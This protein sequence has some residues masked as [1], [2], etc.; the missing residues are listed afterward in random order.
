MHTLVLAL[1]LSLSAPAAAMSADE[2]EQIRLMDEM[3]QLARRNVWSGVDRM[4]RQLMQMDAQLSA[5]HHLQGAHAA[6]GLGEMQTCYERLRAAV[7]LEP[8][9]E[10]VDWLW[11]IDSGYGTVEIT[12]E[13][14]A[15]LSAAEVPL[16]A[17]QRRAIEHAAEVLAEEGQFVG[18][19]PAGQYVVSGQVLTVTSGRQVALVL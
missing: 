3:R 2:A 4:Y 7:R 19:L 10:V 13:D 6:Q 11:A 5:T 17:V 9:K 18:L 8:S 16:D 14:G 15:A 12:A 1:L